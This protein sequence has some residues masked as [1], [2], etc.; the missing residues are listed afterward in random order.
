MDNATI[1]GRLKPRDPPPPGSPERPRYRSPPPPVSPDR[2]RSQ[3]SQ[4]SSGARSG[5]QRS[6]ALVPLPESDPSNSHDHEAKSAHSY[7]PSFVQPTVM[8]YGE[9]DEHAPPPSHAY[10]D[11]EGSYRLGGSEQGSPPPA[12]Y[13]LT[14]ASGIPSAAD[15][16]VHLHHQHSF[17]GEL[18]KLASMFMMRPRRNHAWKPDGPKDVGPHFDATF[19]SNDYVQY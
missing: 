10:D 1:P 13:L 18:E 7:N 8:S 11:D 14:P 9:D 2:R 16:H 3:Y 5:G 15:S 6:A 19:F 4:R 17:K 12:S